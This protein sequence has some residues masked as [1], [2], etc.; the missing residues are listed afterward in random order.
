MNVQNS[1][2]VDSEGMTEQHSHQQEP[3]QRSTNRIEELERA[4]HLTPDC[5]LREWNVSQLLR[6]SPNNN[7]NNNDDVDDNHSDYKD[8]KPPARDSL[9]SKK[10]ATKLYDEHFELK[11]VPKLEWRTPSTTLNSGS[12]SHWENDD[13]E[14]TSSDHL[15]ENDEFDNDF[16]RQ[17]DEDVDEASLHHDHNIAVL[18]TGTSTANHDNQEEDDDDTPIFERSLIE[19]CPGVDLPLR[20]SL[21]TQHAISR[22]FTVR[23]ECINCTL[24]VNCIRD[25][26]YILCPMCYCVS[27]LE[28]S[29][30]ASCISQNIDADTPLFETTGEDNQRYSEGSQSF[31]VGLGFVDDEY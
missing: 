8:S 28:L 7:S 31:G 29:F 1:F 2:T 4:Y 21:E 26:Q 27:P 19:L 30:N 17:D 11:P 22:N 6:M 18:N 20:G 25:A 15:L 14:P 12:S 3:E 13:C 24:Q 9:I 16:S 5:D 10:E 23:V